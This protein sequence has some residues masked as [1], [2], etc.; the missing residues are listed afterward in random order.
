MV[1][2]ATQLLGVRDAPS[3]LESVPGG[4]KELWIFYV[5]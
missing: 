1:S 4:N 5:K 3:K 2:D